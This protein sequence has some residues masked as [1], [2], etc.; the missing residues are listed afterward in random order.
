MTSHHLSTW[1]ISF[2]H[3]SKWFKSSCLPK[4]AVT[5]LPCLARPVPAATLPSSPAWYS[6][7]CT[8]NRAA[9]AKLLQGKAISFH[10]ALNAG[11]RA[12]AQRLMPVQRQE[13]SK[14]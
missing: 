6:Y 7:S 9:E 2:M 13:R 8:V 4:A 1:K 11:Q 5:P 3:T 14:G 12:I 10:P